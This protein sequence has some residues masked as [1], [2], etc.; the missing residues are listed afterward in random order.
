MVK[1]QAG[2]S[3]V[4]WGRSR[5][6]DQPEFVVVTHWDSVAALEAFAGPRW[7]E[8]VIEPDEEHLLAEVFCNHYE[9]VD[10]D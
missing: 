10:T 6:S 7:P 1:A 2:C 4:A 5:W 9:T 8:A 3:Q